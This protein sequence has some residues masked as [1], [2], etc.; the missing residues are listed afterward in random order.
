[1]TALSV[2]TMM[3]HL[4]ISSNV[5]RAYFDLDVFMRH[6]FI[7]IL[8]S[9]LSP[10]G[11]VSSEFFLKNIPNLEKKCYSPVAPRFGAWVVSDGA[12]L[13]TGIFAGKAMVDQAREGLCYQKE[14]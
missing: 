3:R 4:I 9:K 2:N 6:F 12:E 7:G 11:S 5:T 10:K 13:K 1:M 8:F 14:T